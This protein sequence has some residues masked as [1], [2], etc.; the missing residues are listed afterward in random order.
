[1]KKLLAA[2][3]IAASSLAIAAP[4]ALATVSTDGCEVILTTENPDVLWVQIYRVIDPEENP[5][6]GAPDTWETLEVV[7]GVADTLGTWPPGTYEAD[8]GDGTSDTFTITCEPEPINEPEI[9]AGE[10]ID[11][12]RWLPETSTQ[13]PFILVFHP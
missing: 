11:R 2:A 3:L 12:S 10:R 4:A 6:T 1:M 7:N 9:T 13:G 5:G 8:W